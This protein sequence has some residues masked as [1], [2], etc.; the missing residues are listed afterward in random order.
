MRPSKQLRNPR[1][2]PTPKSRPWVAEWAVSE[3]FWKDVSS[4]SLSGLLVLG[5]G[6]IGA[7][8]LGIIDKDVAPQVALTVLVSLIALVITIIVVPLI[9][10]PVGRKVGA[11]MSPLLRASARSFTPK[12]MVSSM[13]ALAIVGSGY[14]VWVAV[15]L[16]VL[17]GWALAVT[18]IWG[19]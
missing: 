19:F 12:W 18:A 10:V 16:P 2:L 8:M 11:F 14:T 3:S 7:A 13:E 4:R 17:Y 15:F 5:V 1:P 6:A 9:S